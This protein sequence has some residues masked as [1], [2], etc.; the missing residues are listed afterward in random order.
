MEDLLREWQ[1]EELITTFKGKGNII[2][3]ALFITDEDCDRLI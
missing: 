2:I 3:I 1:C